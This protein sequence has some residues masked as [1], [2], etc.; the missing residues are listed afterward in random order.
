M[1]D[2]P[3]ASTTIERRTS[4][5]KLQARDLVSIPYLSQEHDVARQTA[6]KALTLLMHEGLVE[7]FPGIGY[8]VTQDSGHALTTVPARLAD[9]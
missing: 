6:A 4:V 3:V 8:V 1:R 2:P 7:R 5:G 9:T